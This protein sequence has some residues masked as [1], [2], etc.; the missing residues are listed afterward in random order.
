MEKQKE[1]VKAFCKQKGY[2]VTDE[3]ATVG[4]REDSLSALKEAIES[5]KNTDSKILLMASTNRVVGTVKETTEITELIESAGVKI[6]TLDGSFEAVG[7]YGISYSSLIE[8]SLMG[9]DD[10]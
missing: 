4:S 9:T 10:E 2:T 7:K 1:R 5:A 8:S 6:I 3:I